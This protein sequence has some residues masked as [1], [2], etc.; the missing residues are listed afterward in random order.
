MRKHEISANSRLTGI[1][2]VYGT[3][4]CVAPDSS[5]DSERATVD[6]EIWIREAAGT[7]LVCHLYCSR[8]VVV[9]VDTA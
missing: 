7:Y 3:E 8:V 6:K 9:V 2:R 4:L 5:R 1:K